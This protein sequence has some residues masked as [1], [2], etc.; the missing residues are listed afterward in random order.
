MYGLLTFCHPAILHCKGL[1]ITQIAEGM[2]KQATKT[3]NLFCTIAAK[4]VAYQACLAPNQVVDRF[5]G[6]W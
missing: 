1:K 3:F 2:E 5:E 6:G 4:R